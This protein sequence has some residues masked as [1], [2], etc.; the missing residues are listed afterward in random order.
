MANPKHKPTAEWLSECRTE[1]ERKV[2]QMAVQGHPRGKIAAS[3]D[4]N[5]RHVYKLLSQVAERIALS[6]EPAVNPPGPS[7]PEFPDDDIPVDE[8]RALMSRRFEKR[9][10]HKAAKQWFKIRMPEDKPFGVMVFG[11]PHLDSNGCN[12][13]LLERHV[14]I[15]RQSG[16]Y[17]LNIGD[18][19]DNWPQGSRL[20]SLYAKSDTSTDT[21]AKLAQWFLEESGVRWLVVLL[22]NHDL[23][24]GHTNLK[25][26]I[27]KKPLLLEEWGARF[28]LQAGKQEYKI[29]ASHD[30]PGHSQWN[31]LHG[32][33][34]AA[35]MKSDADLY[36]AGHKHN[37]ALHQEENAHRGFAYWLVRARGYKFDDDYAERL[38]Y[39]EQAE[40]ASIFVVFN[41]G[42][43]SMAGRLQCFADA[44]VGA[45]YLAWL[46]QKK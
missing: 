10:A 23:F 7:F 13:P 15:C 2:V 8:I 4:I 20:L 34:K 18:T 16:V 3:A 11:D 27:H 14:E 6:G 45:D 1:T 38:G 43:R 17:G 29:W 37:W 26:L 12:W 41:P 22:G 36:L 28:I 39:A 35:L 25:H 9:A 31:P 42:A 5:E 44:E 30:F 33:Q 32:P 46:R 40:G 21:A 19:L 24:P